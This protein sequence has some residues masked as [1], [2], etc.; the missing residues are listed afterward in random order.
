MK[1]NE[2]KFHPRTEKRKKDRKKK[3]LKTNG[4]DLKYKRERVCGFESR[5]VS[6]TC[7]F[8]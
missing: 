1:L 6:L 5:S 2:W 7:L 4:L 8:P 3:E